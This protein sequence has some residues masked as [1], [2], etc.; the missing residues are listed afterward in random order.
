M[1]TELAGR[2]DLSHRLYRRGDKPEYRF[3]YRHAHPRLPVW[4]DGQFQIVRWGNKRGESPALPRTGWTWQSTLKE[5]GWA[6][7]YPDELSAASRSATSATNRNQQERCLRANILAAC[8]VSSGTR[9]QRCGLGGRISEPLQRQVAAW[10]REDDERRASSN[11]KTGQRNGAMCTM[12]CDLL[13][14]P[15]LPLLTTSR[16]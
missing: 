9:C 7:T 1:P 13:S 12:S 5:G 8:S 10:E 14:A 16:L 6:G 2:K 3:L 11:R 4:R 15:R